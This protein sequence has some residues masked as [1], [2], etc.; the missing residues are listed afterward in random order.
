[1]IE[2]LERDLV[3]LAPVKLIC[4]LGG[5]DSR[6]WHARARATARNTAI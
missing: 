3:G 6:P 4:R 1:V 2:A 5:F